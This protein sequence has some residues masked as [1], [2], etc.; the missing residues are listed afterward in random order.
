MRQVQEPDEEAVY[1][2]LLDEKTAMKR[3]PYKT[4]TTFRENFG[5]LYR[6]PKPGKK[7]GYLATDLQACVLGWPISSR[8]PKGKQ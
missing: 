4:T 5:H 7:G 8:K 2:E 6:E 3:T 1:F